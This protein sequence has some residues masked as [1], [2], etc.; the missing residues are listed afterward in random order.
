ME[1]R[2]TIK[3]PGSELK[4]RLS[5]TPA[6]PSTM[7]ATRRRVSGKEALPTPPERPCT[8]T[9]RKIQEEIAS[10]SA[11]EY[12][13][14]GV[15]TPE[16]TVES[17]AQAMPSPETSEEPIPSR[18]ADAENIPPLE[19]EVENFPSLKAEVENASSIEAEAEN[20]FSPEATAEAIPSSDS[21]RASSLV[22]LEIAQD[23]SND[24]LGFGLEQEFD[25]VVEAQKV[26]FELS[27]SRLHHPFHG[28]FPSTGPSS[29][30]IPPEVE[31]VPS[32]ESPGAR[33]L[34]GEPTTQDHLLHVEGSPS[35]NRRSA[36]QRGY[37]MR[38]NTKI[39]VASNT[40]EEEGQLPD[41]SG[42]V[43]TEPS[44]RKI[45]QQTWITEPWNGKSRRKSIRT[46]GETSPR[47]KALS[48]GVPPLPG[49]ASNVQ[50]VL[51]AV[52]EDEIPEEE[53]QDFDDTAE[54]GRL[55]VKVVGVKDLDL[56]LLKGI[57]I[58]A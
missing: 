13:T 54:R 7:A 26:A 29:S 57:K 8:P 19:A 16:I 20:I 24:S 34:I 55:F 25:R 9:A 14:E 47:K 58:V 39:V 31:D 56:P 11:S 27:L 32:L 5:L 50:N 41:I 4:T 30:V 1:R 33:G 53:E 37:L 10:D 21:Q 2:A 12:T 45:S 44:Q 28:R 42:A 40:I 46:A 49:Q 35:A 52:H 22:Q 36:R 43:P 15:A 48:V 38:Q 3:A 18:E 6:D 23:Q 51:G 17:A